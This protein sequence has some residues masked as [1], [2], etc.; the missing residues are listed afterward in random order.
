[1]SAVLVLR[2]LWKLRVG[3]EELLAIAPGLG[4]DVPFFFVGGTALGLGRGEQVYPLEAVPRW[5]V[6]LVCPPFGVATAAAY[7]W[8]DGLR[9][10]NMATAEVR[11]LPGT[12]L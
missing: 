9:A 11:Y 8:L 6:V 4:S 7:G 3:D 2:K 5:W 10:R 12:W 1:H